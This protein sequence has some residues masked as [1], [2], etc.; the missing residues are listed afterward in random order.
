MKILA[1]GGRIKLLIYVSKDSF[2]CVIFE[3]NNPTRCVIYENNL[4]LSLP[5]NLDISNGVFI[6]ARSID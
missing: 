2:N 6:E 1:I 3:Q 4:I 5:E